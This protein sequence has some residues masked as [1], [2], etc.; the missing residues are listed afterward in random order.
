M[1]KDGLGWRHFTSRVVSVVR[2]N[3]D[4]QP[5]LGR[6]R[7]GCVPKLGAGTTDQKGLG[8]C[9]G[10]RHHRLVVLSPLARNILDQTTNQNPGMEFD[11][12]PT[13]GSRNDLTFFAG[14]ERLDQQHSWALQSRANHQPPPLFGKIKLC[15]TL[16]TG[17]YPLSQNLDLTKPKRR[18]FI[19]N[20]NFRLKLS[21]LVGSPKIDPICQK[22]K[23]TLFNV[24]TK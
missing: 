15:L 21:L 11:P 7:V 20:H 24:K 3:P 18:R 14:L 19:W 2:R 5:D 23:K 17:P 9:G 10:L 22:T 13:Q 12:S 4:P 16:T 6:L 8:I 1:V